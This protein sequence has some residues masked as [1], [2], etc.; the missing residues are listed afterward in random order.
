MDVFPNGFHPYDHQVPFFEAV[1]RGVKRFFMV[2]HRRAG[3]DMAAWTA[4]IFEAK[5]VEH[6][7]DRVGRAMFVPTQLRMAVQVVSQGNEVGDVGLDLF[8]HELLFD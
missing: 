7:A 5:L 3:K 8:L 1:G 2:W 4:T 6:G